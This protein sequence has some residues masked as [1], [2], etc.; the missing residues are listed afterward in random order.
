MK[1]DSDLM[2]GVTPSVILNLLKARKMY[3]YEMIK[4][5]NERTNNVFQWKEGS[6]YPCLHKLESS[7]LI[8]SEWLTA[9][10]GKRRKYYSL[11][12]NGLEVLDAKKAELNLFL[13]SVNTLFEN[14]LI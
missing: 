14:A 11:T 10:N 3:G 7:K 5:V 1:I 13:H 12:S 6:L 8:Q 2:R 4:V 9:A